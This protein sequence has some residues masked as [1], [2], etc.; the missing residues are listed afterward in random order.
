MRFRNRID[1]GQQLADWL[2][3]VRLVDPV[4]LG[5]PRGGIPVAW[6]VANR[7]GAPLDAFVAHK[8]G[9]PDHAE[10]GIG[11]VAED[12]AD[13]VVTDTVAQL[14]ISPAELAELADRTRADVQHR[15]ETYRGT[16]ALPPLAGRDVIVVDDGLATG[17]TAEA[18]LRALRER[19][20]RQLILAV[21]VGARETVERMSQ[22]ADQV[23]C[24][25]VPEAF[26]AVGEWY[27][28]FRQTTDAE[29]LRMLPRGGHSDMEP[30]G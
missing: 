11:A 24:V 1:A 5:L 27:D 10:L 17:V 16:R 29:V 25:L 7:L 20:P 21:P 15:V 3:A 13:L 2:A 30:D 23:V 28:D 8:V 4:V 18:A 12:W 26:F 6:V 22:L 9:A 14:G 19:D